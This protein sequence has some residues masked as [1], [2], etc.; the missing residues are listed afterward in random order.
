MA[1]DA[2]HLLKV[3]QGTR[4]L[5]LSVGCAQRSRRAQHP[6]SKG[7]WVDPRLD[8]SNTATPTTETIAVEM[9]GT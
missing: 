6:C 7:R 2:F 8:K 9:I 3:C 4:D 5:E 1:S